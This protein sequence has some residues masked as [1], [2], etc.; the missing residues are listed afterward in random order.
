MPVKLSV[1]KN[2][3][4]T[5]TVLSLAYIVA[6]LFLPEHQVLLWLTALLITVNYGLSLTYLFWQGTI[7]LN[8]I[9][10]NLVQLVLYTR[11]HVQIHDIL[12]AIHYSYNNYFIYHT[13]WYDWVKFIVVHILHAIDLV[14]VLSDYGLEL[15]NLKPRSVLAKLVLLSMHVMVGI[16]FWSGMF[17]YFQRYQ[18]VSTSASSAKTQHPLATELLESFNDMLKIIKQARLAG[19]KAAVVLTI[20]MGIVNQWSLQNWLLW[21]LDNIL[22]TLDFGDACQIFDWHLH[23]L[24]NDANSVTIGVFLR[25]EVSFYVLEW[26]NHFYLYLLKGRGQTITELLLISTSPEY[27]SEEQWLAV[28]ALVRFG[29]LAVPPLTEIL[30]KNDSADKRRLIV[31]VLAEI[32]PVAAPS[33]SHLVKLLVDEDER[34]RWTATRALPRIISNWSQSEATRKAI[35]HLVMA[36]E[37][38]QREVRLAAVRT[39]GSMGTTTTQAV[40]ALIETALKDSHKQVR[41][42]AAFALSQMGTAVSE[43]MSQFMEALTNSDNQVR[44]LATEAL[45]NMGTAATQAIPLLVRV[46]LTDWDGN[47]RLVAEQ[48]LK[49]LIPRA[50]SGP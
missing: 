39:L 4:E 5:A 13:H 18:L 1:N 34:M 37:N 36:L 40:S 49:K 30:T 7:T 20:F 22:R 43:A 2:T 21:P 48:A 28:K 15:Q 16:F 11:L 3:I 23:T 17:M 26:V 45:G 12:G 41:L 8:I 14:D 44:L 9:L 25:L 27:S 24:K 46:S 42:A 38:Q 29:S 32:G 35:P 31:E 19:L 47:V 6:T 50:K 33:V 10:L